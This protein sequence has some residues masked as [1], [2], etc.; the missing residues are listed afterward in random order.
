MLFSWGR[1]QGFTELAGTSCWEMY[2][3]TRK[4][5]D[6]SSVT[7]AAKRCDHT[8]QS[9]LLLRRTLIVSPAMHSRLQ[10]FENE[11][12]IRLLTTKWLHST[13][14]RAPPECSF[15]DAERSKSS[16]RLEVIRTA[17]IRSITQKHTHAREKNKEGALTLERIVCSTTLRRSG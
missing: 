4:L 1:L 13:G 12:E 8:G 10:L 17:S 3:H 16:G 15:F 14:S 5:S 11:N 2:L 7:R 6:T 9:A